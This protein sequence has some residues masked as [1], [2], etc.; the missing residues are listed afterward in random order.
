M[1]PKKRSSAKRKPRRHGVSGNPQRRGAQA[2]PHQQDAARD[3]ADLA[4]RMA[5]WAP[6]QPWW[7]ESHERIFTQG[8][9]LAWPTSSV[10]V[11][12]QTCRIVG[13]EFYDRLNSHNEGLHPAQWLRALAELTGEKLRAAVAHGADDWRPLWS[14]LSG[15][16]AT[17]P[18]MITTPAADGSP[19]RRT[20]RDIKDPLDV[21]Q[22]ELDQCAKLL[23]ARGLDPGERGSAEVSMP[24]G[25]PLIA[26]DVYGSR[27]LLA[28]PF[29][30]SGDE[31]DHWYAWD[32][33]WCWLATAVGAGAFASPADALSEW[34]AAVGPAAGAAELSSCPAEMTAR[35]LTPCLQTGPMADMLTGYEPHEL[36]REFYRLRRRA[37]D[38]TVPAPTGS[39]RSLVDT[40][41]QRDVFLEWYSTAHD[42]IP[43]P[44]DAG[45]IVQEWGPQE[46]LDDRCL[47]AC[48]PHRIEMAAHLIRE[49]YDA[50]YA[51]PALRLLPAWTHWCLEHGDPDGDAAD[52]SRA[53]ACRAASELP[54]P[55][56]GEPADQWPFRRP[57]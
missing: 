7:R 17:T 16:A 43:Q 57:E 4:D 41:L 30:Y 31:P 13:D 25:E 8:H 39:G 37:R 26:R 29:G 9:G 50:E 53:A 3:F 12:T 22:V 56:G 23:A 47:Y 49:R 35:L 28:V 2:H 36:I 24:V 19:G 51:A 48:S 40:G 5:G 44:E 32:L 52:R 15:L 6:A 20:R 46:Y 14:L 21:V 18:R 27:F 10:D 1:S 42:D 11:E 38:L 45:T 33:D 34:R 55:H 54:D